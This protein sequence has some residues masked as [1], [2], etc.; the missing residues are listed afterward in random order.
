MDSAELMNGSMSDMLYHHY[1]VYDINDDGIYEFI[2]KTGN[3]EADSTYSVYSIED[4]QMTFWGDISAGNSV[5]TEKDGKLYKN[6]CHTGYQSVDL[7]SFDGKSVSTENVYE[8]E[9]SET[10]IDYGTNLKYYDAG[11]T[12]LLSKLSY[13]YYNT[14][15]AGS[16][17]HFTQNQIAKG[18]T[19]SVNSGA[20][21]LRTAPDLNS[22]ILLEMPKD[23]FISIY[24]N[25]DEWY[26]V[27]YEENSITYYGYASRQYIT[28]S[29]DN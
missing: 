25:N 4:N 8:K 21:N 22:K 16:D 28:K 11:D 26:Y 20:L 18:G 7:I 14:D 12:A 24:G 9:Q 1:Y 27:S 15:K 6:M 29:V 5:L 13:T 2:T 3:G 10:Y 23:S 19:V 17:F